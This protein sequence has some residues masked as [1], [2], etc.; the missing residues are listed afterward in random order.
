[1]FLKDSIFFNLLLCLD[2]DIYICNEK[3][4]MEKEVSCS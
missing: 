4:K 1:M 2:G 3:T